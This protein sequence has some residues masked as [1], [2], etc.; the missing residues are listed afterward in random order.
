MVLPMTKSALGGTLLVGEDLRNMLKTATARDEGKVLRAVASYTDGH[1]N[2]KKAV[3]VSDNP[4]RAEVSSQ[5]D[6][7]RTGKRLTG[8][9]SG[10]DYSRTVS[11]SLA[12]DMPWVIRSWQSTPRG[13]SH[14]SDVHHHW[15]LGLLQDR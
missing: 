13:H 3:G 5:N 9:P 11:E 4:V 10:A 12:K 8:F 2:E 15:R 1:G 6:T 14:L 7:W